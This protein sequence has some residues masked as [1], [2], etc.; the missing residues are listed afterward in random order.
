MDALAQIGSFLLGV[1]VF[2]AG[3]AAIWWVTMQA[4][5]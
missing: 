3:I 5:E 2:L 1:G 4:G